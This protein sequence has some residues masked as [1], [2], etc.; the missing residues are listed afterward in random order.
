MQDD[1]D[2]GHQQQDMDHC[3]RNVERQKPKQPHNYQNGGY[4]PK[5]FSCLFNMV[6]AAT[7]RRPCS[8]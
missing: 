8:W 5:H 2:H 6:T 7:D 3:R 1:H 4:D